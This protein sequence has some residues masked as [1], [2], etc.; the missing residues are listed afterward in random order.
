MDE[1][2][3]KTL[4][5]NQKEVSVCKAIL[6]NVKIIYQVDA[7]TDKPFKGNPAGVMFSNEAMAPE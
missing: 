1:K 7:F 5:D 4:V 2:I 3:I 6:G